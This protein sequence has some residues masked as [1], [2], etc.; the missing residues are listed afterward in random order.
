[1]PTP[2][3]PS[4]AQAPHGPRRAAPAHSARERLAWTS[5]R[6]PSSLC[7]VREDPSPAAFR[8]HDEILRVVGIARLASR[9]L[10]SRRSREEWRP[11]LRVL[12]VDGGRRRVLPEP[13]RRL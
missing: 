12:H 4:A 11:L 7:L 8:V 2:N 9:A 5:G 10:P 3:T 6:Q 13:H 1:G